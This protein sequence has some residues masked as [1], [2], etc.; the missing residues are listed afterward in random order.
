MRHIEILY[1]EFALYACHLP[2]LYPLYFSLYSTFDLERGVVIPYYFMG[3]TLSFI[4]SVPV[5]L[6]EIYAHSLDR[7]NYYTYLVVG[8]AI[9]FG[10]KFALFVKVMN[11]LNV[12][13]MLVANNIVEALLLYGSVLRF[14][15]YHGKS[16][17]RYTGYFIY[18]FLTPVSYFIIGEFLRLLG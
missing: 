11:T 5:V 3:L 7:P 2:I 14:R 12:P 17:T 16:V 13:Y 1:A 18:L 4:F 10:T 15:Y 6:Y 8:S 9:N